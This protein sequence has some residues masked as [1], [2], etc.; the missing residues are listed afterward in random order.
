MPLSL[1]GT[2]WTGLEYTHN[3]KERAEHTIIRAGGDLVAEVVE[4][5]VERPHEEPVVRCGVGAVQS[6]RHRA[7]GR[8]RTAHRLRQ[9]IETFGLRA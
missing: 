4:L 3:T 8:V 5:D 7:A 6:E 9:L 2:H 1:Y